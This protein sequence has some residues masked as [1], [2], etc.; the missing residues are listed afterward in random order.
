MLKLV[1][2]HIKSDLNGEK[3]IGSSYD[4]KLLLSNL[5]MSCYPEP[6][7]EIV[8]VVLDWTNYAT[9]KVLEHTTSIYRFDLTAKKDFIFLTNQT[10]K[11][12]LIFQLV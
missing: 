4:K 8:K 10:L 12:W 11:N 3:I 2:G 6:N 7:L 9:K 1:Q 5:Y